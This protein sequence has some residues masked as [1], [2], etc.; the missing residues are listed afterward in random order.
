MS[1]LAKVLSEIQLIEAEMSAI[2]TKHESLRERLSEIGPSNDASAAIERAQIQNILRAVPDAETTRLSQQ[3]ADAIERE[4]HVRRVANDLA[5]TLGEWRRKL[6]RAD[7]TVA[8]SQAVLSRLLDQ[9]QGI[10]DEVARLE[11]QRA[12]LVG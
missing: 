1:E 7:A 12:A 2:A 8:E 3:R 10:A 4:K 9:R 11:A 6:E 5:R